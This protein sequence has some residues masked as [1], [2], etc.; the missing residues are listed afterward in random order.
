MVPQL[1]NWTVVVTINPNSTHVPFLISDTNWTGHSSAPAWEGCFL[2]TAMGEN[3][4]VLLT[5]TLLPIL[6]SVS[7][8][9]MIS[10]ESVKLDIYLYL[11]DYT[12]HI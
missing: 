1:Q 5:F 7:V 4:T 6:M 2:T 3:P 9:F 10:I 11:H 12:I 8:S